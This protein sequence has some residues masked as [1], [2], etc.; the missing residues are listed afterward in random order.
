VIYE[1]K[2]W[3]GRC[4]KCG[5]EF[6][7]KFGD[8]IAESRAAARAMMIIANWIVGDDGYAVCREC[9]NADERVVTRHAGAVMLR[10]MLGGS[11]DTEDSQCE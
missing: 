5:L 10:R 7:E 11:T 4:D 9:Q 8:G 1:I 6:R 2:A 3:T